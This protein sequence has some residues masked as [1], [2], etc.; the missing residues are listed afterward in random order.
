MVSAVAG[1]S[2]SKQRLE[3][4]RDWLVRTRAAE[5]LFIL[6]LGLVYAL[7]SIWS[8]RTL[9]WF[10]LVPVMVIVAVPYRSLLPIV[11]SPVFIA[12]ALFLLLVLA[13]SALGGET[14]AKI[15]TL[16]LRYA[17]AVLAFVTI[18][19][20]LVRDDGDFLRMLFLVIGP[21][22]A[23]IAIRDV[24]SFTGLSFK[25]L[26]TVRLEGVK[27]L[28]VY[29]NSN[30]IGMMFAM[31]CVGAA[32]VMASRSLK[33][34][35]YVML[36]ASVLV[37]LGAI[38]LTGSRG[39]LIAAAVGIGVAIMLSEHRRLKLALIAVAVVLVCVV[40]IAPFQS[41]LLQ[42]RDSLRLALWPIYLEM[43]AEKP[44]L[45]YGLA[46]DTQR[47][48]SSGNV[49]MNAHN[50]VLCALVRGGIFTA[51]AL[52]GIVLA[53]LASGFRAWRSSGEVVALAL[54]AACLTASSV[55]YEI[56]PTDLAY[57]YILFWLP[58]GVCL[59]AGLSAHRILPGRRIR[60]ETVSASS[61]NRQPSG[62]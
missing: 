59:G 19:A 40:M 56:V 55:D 58:V 27:G 11:K 34:W 7:H 52:I 29:Y 36:A 48:L 39:S 47:T 21:V 57:L 9:L 38:L 4:T 43:A 41:E 22:A 3:R 25:T 31:P 18:T 51:L 5:K 61:Q 6:V 24:A 46:F 17:V 1:P 20:Y 16:N 50:I 42:R 28:T 45:G 23:L 49:V 60:P 35:Q 53:A 14:P 37:L 54:L 13:T 2:R 12:S 30:V 33:L 32:A 26:M 15:L 8:A 44:W 10:V 62:D